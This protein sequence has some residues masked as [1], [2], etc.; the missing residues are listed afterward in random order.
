MSDATTARRLDLFTT[1]D[2]EGFNN[3]NWEVFGNLHTDDV[4]CEVNGTRT[5]DLESHLAYC[6]Q[7]FHRAPDTRIAEHILKFGDGEWTCTVGLMTG[8]GEP[9]QMV[10]V[11][12]W[13]GEQI[14]EEYIYTNRAG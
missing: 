1:L 12:R 4:I 2:F 8:M 11:A 9:F 13:R 3:Q 10:T 5:E 14:C 6:Q 7:T